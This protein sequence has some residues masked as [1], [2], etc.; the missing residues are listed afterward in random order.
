[1]KE[2][3]IEL[4]MLNVAEG[5]ETT[6]TVPLDTTRQDFADILKSYVYQGGPYVLVDVIIGEEDQ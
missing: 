5:T 3:R 1:M 6:V 2:N 4:I